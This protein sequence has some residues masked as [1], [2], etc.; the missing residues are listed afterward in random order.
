VVVHDGAREQRRVEGVVGVVVAEHHVG[1]PGRAV[2][3]GGQRAEQRV[4]A[5][6][7]ARID[8]D[9]PA[10]VH[11]QGDRAAHPVR[12]VFFPGVPLVQHEYLR[13]PGQCPA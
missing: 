13:G 4:T 12:V 8:D 3:I 2:H 6:H 1:H 10:A 9:H 11:D 7:H 5:G